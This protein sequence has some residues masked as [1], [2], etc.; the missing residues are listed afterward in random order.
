[1]DK[2]RFISLAPKYYALAIA[3]HL[4]HD[5]IVQRNVL[6]FCLA[7]K[8]ELDG[9]KEYLIQKDTLLTAAL[10]YLKEKRFIER[11]EDDFGPEVIVR[12]SDYVESW[13]AIVEAGEEPFRKYDRLKDSDPQWLISA[14]R[15]V[16]ARYDELKIVDEDF[17]SPDD[18]WAPIPMDRQSP[19]VVNSIAALSEAVIQIEQDNGYAAH[20]PEER[21]HVLGAL[22][23]TLNRLKTETQ[24]SVAYLRIN[25]LEPLSI[26]V[27]RFGKAAVGVAATAAGI[28]ILK[29]VE[30]VGTQ[31]MMEYFRSYFSLH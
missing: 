10:Q 20:V 18:E 25:A 23:Q 30:D 14:I 15:S 13:N 19:D 3:N 7:T 4:L 5:E 2:H 8:N 9:T 28:A 1:M 31:T 24:T 12:S 21:A 16:N 6:F 17:V 26:I 29:I 27:R 11:L 22:T